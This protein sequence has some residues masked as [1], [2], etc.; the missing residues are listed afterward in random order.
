M[1]EHL[2]GLHPLAR[3]SYRRQA[4]SSFQ[5]L[6]HRSAIHN[7]ARTR[8]EPE[9]DSEPDLDQETPIQV[10][11]PVVTSSNPIIPD[12][13]IDLKGL[14]L[15]QD[16]KFEALAE[17]L[18][19]FYGT[20]QQRG[21]L[22][23]TSFTATASYLKLRLSRRFLDSK[24]LRHLRIEYLHG[25]IA[26]EERARVIDEIRE[27]E[28][29]FLMVLT[30]IGQE[31]IDLQFATGVFHYDL[32]WNPMRLVQRNGRVHRIGQEAPRIF[33]HTF[34]VNHSL[35]DRIEQAIAR[36]M[37]LV[38]NTFGDLPEGLFGGDLT[39]SLQKYLQ[40]SEGFQ[41]LLNFRNKAVTEFEEKSSR[42][43][44]TWVED[45]QQIQIHQTQIRQVLSEE[46][47]ACQAWR[48]L[49]E[50][51]LNGAFGSLE[52]VLR[53][54]VESLLRYS[55]QAGLGVDSVQIDQEEAI[56]DLQWQNL[57]FDAETGAFGR[58]IQRRL[59]RC[60][61]MKAQILADDGQKR[62]K[63]LEPFQVLHLA[64]PI[65]AKLSRLML[66][67]IDHPAALCSS[68]RIKE[69]C[70]L[71]CV[72]F[73]VK[74]S[75]GQ[76]RKDSRWFLLEQ[77]A[78][79]GPWI[80]LDH[81]GSAE[82]MDAILEAT[83]PWQAWGKE[84]AER[85]TDGLRSALVDM[86]RVLKEE[87][88]EQKLRHELKRER[89][90]FRQ[91]RKVEEHWHESLREAEERVRGLSVQ[92][93]QLDKVGEGKTVYAQSVARQLANE[94]RRVTNS[95]KSYETYRDR[96]GGVQERIDT[97]KREG[98]RGLRLLIHELTPH[99]VVVF[100]PEVGA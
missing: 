66:D 4:S 73:E 44:E 49:V 33:I 57:R 32:P 14:H 25:G 55:T 54:D 74:G 34:L 47:D 10:E 100:Q 19:N 6:L 45:T 77:Q 8:P 62:R 53:T 26:P 7:L 94:R 87:L 5:A 37:E 68:P 1:I 96:S 65:V 35:D 28:G 13:P 12:E 72:D 48:P 60:Q 75:G 71:V 64:H 3:V 58:D 97:L 36:R 22:I 2:D 86:Q 29:P 63:D 70:V 85:L 92:Q 95:R 82:R 43:R 91:L 20:H 38:Y 89:R 61:S 9:P 88:I 50:D 17:A 93:G 16:S 51:A 69:P 42:L 11:T 41:S 80:R 67:R 21:A 83:G 52:R 56:W 39:G 40:G 99:A 30:E 59:A 31:G 81:R 23:F 76:S 98:I 27:H 18:A 84:P 90:Q 79:D 15:L 46:A 78:K 24:D